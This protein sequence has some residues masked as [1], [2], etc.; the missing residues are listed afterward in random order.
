[1]KQKKK[2]RGEK[3]HSHLACDF[4]HTTESLRGA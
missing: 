2:K 4:T 1:M 3:G